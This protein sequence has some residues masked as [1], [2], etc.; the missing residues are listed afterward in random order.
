MGLALHAF[1]RRP[2]LALAASLSCTAPMMG[3]R[4]EGC[5]APART[6]PAACPRFSHWPTL[7]SK[8]QVCCC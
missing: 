7:P 1:P 6:A 2:F 4:F 3:D 5:P 8:E